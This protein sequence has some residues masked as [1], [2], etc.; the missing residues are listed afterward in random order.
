MISSKLVSLENLRNYQFNTWEKKPLEVKYP[1]RGEMAV[2]LTSGVRDQLSLD[3]WTDVNLLKIVC[4]PESLPLRWL[5]LH[6]F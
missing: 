4:S 6:F 3:D 5:L 1:I 2:H